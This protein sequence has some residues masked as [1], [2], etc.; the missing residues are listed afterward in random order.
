MKIEYVKNL[1]QNF[2]KDYDSFT[3]DQ[4]IDEIQ[5]LSLK[6]D[7]IVIVESED[8]DFDYV[9]TDFSF[10]SSQVEYASSLLTQSPDKPITFIIE[11]QE[12]EE[13]L[14]LY[15]FTLSEKPFSTMYLISPLYLR[16]STISILEDQLLLV[17]LSSIIF[18]FFI[19]FFLARKISTPI[20]EL[21]H[22][23]ELLSEGNYGVKF[24]SSSKYG[25]YTELKRLTHSFNTA[26]SK[27]HS[28]ATLQ[29]DLMANVSHDLKT[30]LTMIIS[31]A[32][33]I[34][35]ISGNDPEKREA[36]LNV[37]M[38]EANRLNKLVS[39]MLLLSNIQSAPYNL[40][41]EAFVVKDLIEG[42]IQTFNLY[43][44]EKGHKLTLSCKDSLKAMG[45]PDK[46]KQVLNNL[47]TNAFKFSKEG[48]PIEILITQIDLKS[49]SKIKFEVKDKGIG[50]EEKDIE[51]VWDR[52]YRGSSNHTRNS[53]GSGLGLSITKEILDLHQANYGI[54]SVVGNGST[55]WFELDA[56]K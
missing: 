27:L 46:I 55:F 9:S 32:E 37:I 26:S 39:D 44:L 13:N 47:L 8:A 22:T 5:N 6:D 18:S 29:K 7:M 1:G 41:S 15:G 28:S 19:G 54:I 42:I 31:Y 38:D 11:H 34:K 35:D 33:M 56:A 21:T 49:S 10:A 12:T 36:H 2:A 43:A 52:Y 23:A 25:K 20:R 24:T 30:P 48:A 50:I 17:F 16:S 45:E 14:V 3:K 53:T 51:K 40:K 4:A